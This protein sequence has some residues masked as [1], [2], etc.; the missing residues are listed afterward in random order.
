[1]ESCNKENSLCKC[2]KLSSEEINEVSNILKVYNEAIIEKYTPKCTDKGF[3]EVETTTGT[4][5]RFTIYTHEKRVRIGA[6]SLEDATEPFVLFKEALHYIGKT[7][8]DFFEQNDSPNQFW[9]MRQ[10][11]DLTLF[12]DYF[13]HDAYIISY[14]RCR[15]VPNDLKTAYLPKVSYRRSEGLHVDNLEDLN[16]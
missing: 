16:G 10:Q 15:Q 13:T 9:V 5:P 3:Y 1:M 14:L 12:K 7:F 8:V 6:E 11:I 2:L 4:N